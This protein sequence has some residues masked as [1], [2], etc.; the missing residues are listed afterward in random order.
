M[1]LDKLLF[2]LAFPITVFAGFVVGR[3]IGRALQ[4]IL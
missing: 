1:T 2:V 3:M 4:V